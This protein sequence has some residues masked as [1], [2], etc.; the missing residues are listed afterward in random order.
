MVRQN[1]FS[2]ITKSFSQLALSQIQETGR[3]LFNHNIINTSKR[4]VKVFQIIYS[5]EKIWINFPVLP[6]FLFER[7][8]LGSLWEKLH[9]SGPRKMILP[10]PFNDENMYILKSMMLN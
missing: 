9:T 3:A 4:P 7:K 6:I 8:Q 2:Y 1:T 10:M 5:T